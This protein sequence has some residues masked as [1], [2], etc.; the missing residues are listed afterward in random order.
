MDNSHANL[1]KLLQIITEF[2]FFSTLLFTYTTHYFLLY[3]FFFTQTT[4]VSF[5]IPTKILSCLCSILISKLNSCLKGW[6]SMYIHTNQSFKKKSILNRLW[7]E[8]NR[9]SI[10]SRRDIL[11]T[12]LLSEEVSHKVLSERVSPLIKPWDCTWV[13]EWRKIPPFCVTVFH[14]GNWNLTAWWLN[15]I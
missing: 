11:I 13:P 8:I 6:F 3:Y 10:Y 15:G 4:L 2:Q 1:Y 7:E 12:W 14:R 9:L 5:F